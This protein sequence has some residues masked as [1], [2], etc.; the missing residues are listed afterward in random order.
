[1]R[2]MPCLYIFT[3]LSLCYYRGFVLW[4]R[5]STTLFQPFA[6]RYLIECSYWYLLL[7]ASLTAFLRDWSACLPSYLLAYLS[8]V[9]QPAC[10]AYLPDTMP[11]C[12]SGRGHIIIQICSF[13]TKQP[14]ATIELLAWTN[15]SVLSDRDTYRLSISSV[16][17][18]V[19]N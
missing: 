13:R 10:L 1:M 6:S 12:Q 17:S 11:A 14:E 3:T 9:R 18:N 5:Y 2:N 7:L 15:S 8:D 16:Q 4:Q 19:I